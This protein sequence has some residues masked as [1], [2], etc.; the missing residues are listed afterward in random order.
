MPNDDNHYDEAHAMLR[1]AYN[2]RHNNPTVET[3]PGEA[4]A[5][6]AVH[7]QLAVVDELRLAN[8]A[9]DVKVSLP[10]MPDLGYGYGY[11]TNP[12]YGEAGQR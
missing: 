12:G 10:A 9:G 6:A 4:L 11:G 8:R 7:A 2:A 5:F 3:T 1:A